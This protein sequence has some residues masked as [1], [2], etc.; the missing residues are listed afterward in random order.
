MRWERLRSLPREGGAFEVETLGREH[1]FGY[2][3]WWSTLGGRI[4]EGNISYWYVL[5]VFCA[6]KSLRSLPR[7]GVGG[8]FEVATDGLKS[9]QVTPNGVLC[10]E[11]LHSL[12]RPRE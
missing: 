3:R 8:W 12:P 5:K 1:G 7:E 4:P 10:F 6:F 2:F 9:Y 11:S